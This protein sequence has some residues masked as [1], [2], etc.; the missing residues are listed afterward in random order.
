MADTLPASL[1]SQ[2]RIG[3]TS[4]AAS[5]RRKTEHKEKQPWRRFLIIAHLENTP[6]GVT[7]FENALL[8]RSTACP[9]QFMG[10]MLMSER[11]RRLRSLRGLLPM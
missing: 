10:L 4:L 3:D 11:S 5:R 2:G 9:N 8:V 6:G 7:H 1:C